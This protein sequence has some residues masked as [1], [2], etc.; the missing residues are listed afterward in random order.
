MQKAYYMNLCKHCKATQGVNFTVFHPTEI[1]SLSNN[2]L[3]KKI[4]FKLFP[5]E[6][7]LCED[8]L[9]RFIQ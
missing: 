1:D 3:N 9:I 7:C 4:V 6:C 5:Q 8:D 2:E